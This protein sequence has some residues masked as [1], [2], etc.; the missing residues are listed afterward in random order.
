MI[1]RHF[2]TSL[3]EV[4]TLLC[5]VNVMTEEVTFEHDQHA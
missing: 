3:G 2:R 5:A 1:C 4:D